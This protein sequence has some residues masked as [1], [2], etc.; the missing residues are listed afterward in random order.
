[1]EYSPFSFSHSTILRK[2]G[3]VGR[4]GSGNDL[5]FDVSIFF[6]KKVGFLVWIIH[7]EL[8]LT[9]KKKIRNTKGE[10]KIVYGITFP[11]VK[12]VKTVHNISL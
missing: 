3:V 12:N 11:F 2:K 8:S 7:P 9:D 1:M 10:E 5:N 4:L 6:K